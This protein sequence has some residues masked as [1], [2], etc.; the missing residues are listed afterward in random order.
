[1]KQF[2]PLILLSLFFFIHFNLFG[3]HTHQK[4]DAIFECSQSHAHDIKMATDESYQQNH[5]AF[6]KKLHQLLQKGSQDRNPAPFTLPVV[7]HIIH[8]NGSENISDTQVET[9][10]QHLNDAFAN[11]GYYNPATGVNTEISFCL[12]KR[13]PD[14]DATTGILRVQSPLTE[15]N[16]NADDQT[17]KDLSRF[18]PLEYINI[19]VVR[20]IC[21]NNGCGVAGYAYLPAA[22][23]A[24][25]DGIVLEASYM[26]STPAF[27]SVLVH[28]MGHYL[29]L[30]HTFQGGCPNSDC[31]LNGDRVCDTPPDNTTARPPCPDDMNS[32][33]TDEDDT[34]INN[35]FRPV[36]LGGLGDQVD[37]KENYMDYSRLECYDRFSQGQADR[38][39]DVID[40]IR[41][42]LL[43]SPA[44]IDPCPIPFEIGFMASATNVPVG[45]TVNFTNTTIGAD[46]YE[47]SITGSVFSTTQNSS[48]T[49]TQEGTYAITLSAFSNLSDCLPMDSTITIEVFCPIDADFTASASSVLAGASVSF[50]NN[51]TGS[52]DAYNWLV[53]GVSVSNSTDLTF[54]TPQ[55][56]GYNV[57]L[58]ASNAD[59]E[60]VHCF[61]LEAF[62]PTSDC[63]NGFV[64]TYGSPEFSE[65]ANCI[66]PA[67]DGGF[68]VGGARGAES[69]IMKFDVNGIPVW[70]KSF[71]LSGI[72]S[73]SEGVYYLLEDGD[74]LIGTSWYNSNSE[75]YCFKYDMVNDDFVWIR[76]ITEGQTS[77]TY[78]IINMENS[79]NYILIGYLQTT[80]TQ[81]CNATYGTLDKFTGNLLSMKEYHLGSCESG[82]AAV[83]VNDKIYITGRYNAAGGGVFAMRPAISQLELDGTEN[84]SRLYLVDAPTPT[85]R[86]YSGT[87]LEDQGS[88]VVA[89]QGDL[90]GTSATD[91]TA[92]IFKT[93]LD[94][95]ILWASIFDFPFNSQ[96]CRF[97]QIVDQGDG[98]LA[99]GY[100]TF[101]GQEDLIFVKVDPSGNFMWART[102]P[103]NDAEVTYNKGAFAKD[104][105]AYITASRVSNN[106]SDIL[107]LKISPDGVIEGD[108]EQLTDIQ[109]EFWQLQNPFDGVFNVNEANVSHQNFAGQAFTEDVNLPADTL[110]FVP[111]VELCNNGLD[112]DGDGLADCDDPDC[113]C[114]DDCGNTFVKA[115]GLPQQNESL[116]TV[117]LHSSGYLYAGGNIQNDG[118]LV[119]MSTEGDVLLQQQFNLTPQPDRILSLIEDDDGFVI[120]VGFGQNVT[121]GRTGFIFKYNPNTES[122]IWSNTFS[123]LTGFWTVTIN[124]T[125]GNYVAAGATAQT[126]QDAVVAEFN[127]F[128]GTLSWTRFID[129]GASDAFYDIVPVGNFLYLP[130]RYTLYSNTDEMRAGITAL[131]N[132]G[133]EQWSK[134]YLYPANANARQ[135]A[136]A[137]E[138]DNGGLVSAIC[139]NPNGIPVNGFKTGLM[140]TDYFGNLEWATEYDLAGYIGEP[141]GYG[142]TTTPDG[143]LLYGYG[144]AGDED[145]IIIKTDKLGNALWARAYGG[146]LDDDFLF[147][148]DN[149]LVQSGDY[150]YIVGRTRYFSNSE[151]AFIIKANASDGSV[152]DDDCI[153]TEL[154]DVSTTFYQNPFEGNEPTSSNPYTDVINQ[155]NAPTPIIPALNCEVLCQGSAFDLVAIIDSAYCNGDSLGMSIQIC[156]EGSDMLMPGVAYTIYD[157]DPRLSS[158]ATN[159]GSYLVPDTILTGECFSTSLNIPYPNNTIFLVANDNGALL[160]PFDPETD[161]PVTDISEC[162]YSNNLD[163]L[164]FE[165]PTFTLDL[166]PDTTICENGIFHLDA[167]PGFVN[168]LWQDGSFEQTLTA[169][170]AGTYWVEVTTPCGDVLSDTINIILENEILITLGA[171]TTICSG[172][173][174]TLSTLD[175]PAYTYEWFP[176]N[177][178][179]C[180][181]CPTVTASPTSTTTYELVVSNASGCVSVDSIIVN[182]ENCTE[183]LDTTLCL[184]DSLVIEGQA[185][186]PNTM[187]TLTLIDGNRISR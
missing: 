2:N 121:S 157:G 29:G 123:T 17:V 48:Y 133:V 177:T 101:N 187:D 36:N 51:S 55:P 165:P 75:H 12:T 170:E 39:H 141:A 38:M 30:Y 23:G 159:I 35:P 161:F 77:R 53:N 56:G 86:L 13:D 167:G 94:G 47:W 45:T 20:E 27:S 111:C 116:S 105:Y 71:E 145:L 7:V 84:W 72:S 89:G 60:D 126:N 62:A 129:I 65:R 24:T 186:Y 14:G 127:R 106:G 15:F 96:T 61:F 136:F 43:A 22:H 112:D 153:Y 69:L 52:I 114:F 104:G 154:V 41:Y 147:N 166:G 151:D 110:C 139:G 46:N 184:G 149:Q 134:T 152:N 83:V 54:S 142:M 4:A 100:H 143:F 66:T 102:L 40:N 11:T 162:E 10:I 16:Y 70:Q 135:Y 132:I 160:P 25:F 175:D 82:Q 108:C 181:T 64:F 31:Q 87:I 179:D 163:S 95:N 97:S 155:V 183:I 117:L 144:I 174:V 26:G 90:D 32:C 58:E 9:A 150:I 33:T 122:I 172:T 68:Y 1:M 173:S 128:T 176:S 28:E 5:L 37:M 137:M 119:K 130:T 131:N 8:D 148:A 85:A 158:S 180:N 42:S 185:L 34:S 140:R 138:Q 79:P 59:C 115:L 171:D 178:L 63:G 109:V 169:F 91:I 107:L 93:D 76:A 18:E 113:P 80:S 120:G 81:G 19:W 125:N 78:E 146:V 3:Q 49:F 164:I 92:H 74:Y 67:D 98:Y 118:L 21:N 103:S 124:P 73:T 156:N 57:C 44:C 168:Y 99:V 182:V 6:E 88:L 50:T